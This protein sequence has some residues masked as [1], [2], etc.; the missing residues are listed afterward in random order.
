MC[1]FVSIMPYMLN[2][3]D[4]VTTFFFSQANGFFFCQR[5]IINCSNQSNTNIL[6]RLSCQGLLFSVLFYKLCHLWNRGVKY[7]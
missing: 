3:G 5:L 2:I 4:E 1:N 7:V 6:I